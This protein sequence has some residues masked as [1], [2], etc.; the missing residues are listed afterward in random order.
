MAILDS[1]PCRVRLTTT[2]HIIHASTFLSSL[3]VSSSQLT[4]DDL[5]KNTMKTSIL[6][7]EID[8][9]AH[10]LHQALKK[11]RAGCDAQSD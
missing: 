2:T 3:I 4:I 8:E 6:L 5:G 1:V 10:F 9:R 11:Q 7:D